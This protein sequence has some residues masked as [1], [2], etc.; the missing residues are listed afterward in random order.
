[1]SDGWVGGWE[2]G[3]ARRGRGYGGARGGAYA[4]PP[5]PQSR[6]GRTG[7]RGR[8]GSPQPSALRVSAPPGRSVSADHGILSGAPRIR[9]RSRGA[10]SAEPG[11]SRGSGLRG[12]RGR[13]FPCAPTRAAR[14]PACQPA[15]PRRTCHSPP[16]RVGSLGFPGPGP[17]APRA[18]PSGLLRVEP[19][20]SFSVLRETLGSERPQKQVADE[21]S[22]GGVTWTHLSGVETGPLL[23]SFC[24]GS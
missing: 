9:K 10:E 13:R 15:G 12:A 7:T 17:Q 3:G 21:T 8:P 5:A 4:H 1:M 23:L 24:T 6:A 11:A 16:G 14:G 18:H 22:G 20:P 2:C 19:R